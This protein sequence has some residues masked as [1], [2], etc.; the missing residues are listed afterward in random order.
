MAIHS[1]VHA[2]NQNQFN[3]FGSNSFI[4]TLYIHEHLA[5]KLLQGTRFEPGNGYIAVGNFQCIGNESSLL[6]CT[7]GTSPN[8]SHHHD[9]ELLCSVENCTEGDIFLFEG[10]S[11]F[12]GTVEVCINGTL[13]TV[14]DDGWDSVDATVACRQ[15]GYSSIGEKIG[16]MFGLSVAYIHHSYK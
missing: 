15:L 12:H 4:C 1:Q 16:S 8:C 10:D 5:H 14:C 13:G 6:G 9:V 7:F 3:C 2:N 11:P